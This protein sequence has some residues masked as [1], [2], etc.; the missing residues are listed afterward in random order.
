MTT[1][2]LPICDSTIRAARVAEFLFELQHFRSDDAEDLL[3]ILQQILKILDERFFLFVFGFQFL[4]LQPGQ[5]PQRH[6]EGDSED[7]RAHL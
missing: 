4:A 7:G 1:S 3:F 2:P 6:I 5:P